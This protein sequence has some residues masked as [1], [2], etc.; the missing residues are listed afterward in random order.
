MVVV[1]GGGVIEESGIVGVAGVLDHEVS[2]RSIFFFRLWEREIKVKAAV[3]RDGTYEPSIDS[4]CR[5]GI[6]GIPS[7]QSGRHLSSGRQA[8][9][10]SRKRG[11]G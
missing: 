6:A 7:R 4:T 9:R 1:R 11:H 8:R 10:L 5:R 3:E 2:G